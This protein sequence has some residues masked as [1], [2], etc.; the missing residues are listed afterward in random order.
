MKPQGRAQFGN[1]RRT[2]A[3][4]AT[5]LVSLLTMRMLG[6]LDFAEAE[7]IQALTGAAS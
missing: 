5:A 4:K 7:E 2:R 6:V 1:R 3:D